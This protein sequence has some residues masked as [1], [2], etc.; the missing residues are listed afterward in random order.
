MAQKGGSGDST[1]ASVASP[2][3]CSR[4]LWGDSSRSRHRLRPVVVGGQRRGNTRSGPARQ[5]SRRQQRRGADRA[6]PGQPGHRPEPGAP[7][8]VL[9][10]RC[11]GPEPHPLRLRRTSPAMRLMGD[12]IATN[13][14]MLGF[15]VQKGLIPL[16]LETDRARR[17]GSTAWRSTRTS[18][19]LNWGRLAAQDPARFAKLWPAPGGEPAS[20]RFRRHWAKSSSGGASMLDGLPGCGV[21]RQLPQVRRPGSRDERAASGARPRSRR[22]WR[23]RSRSS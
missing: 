3:S 8:R 12:S 20:S 18:H 16:G 17:S 22:P 7:A 13:I 9:A 19:A 6:V 1:F 15:A 14:F 4:R 2:T 11:P 21:R 10:K 5:R 23:C